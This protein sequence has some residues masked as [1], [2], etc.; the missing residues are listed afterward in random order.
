MINPHPDIFPLLISLYN[1]HPR[2]Y[3]DYLGEW[4]TRGEAKEV[5]KLIIKWIDETNYPIYL[6]QH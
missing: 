6:N 1:R 3:Y 4:L 5:K 2:L